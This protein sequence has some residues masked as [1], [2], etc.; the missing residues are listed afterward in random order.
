MAKE[1]GKVVNM[2]NEMKEAN[3]NLEDEVIIK[4][5]EKEFKLE[6]EYID[7]D[8]IQ[9]INEEYQEKLP[10][11]PMALVETGDGRSKNIQIPT[12]EEKYKMFNTKPENKKKIKAWEKK[13]KPYEKER[14]YRIAWELLKDEYKPKDSEGNIIPVDKAIEMWIDDKMLKYSD[15]LKIMNKGMSL[16]NFGDQ[17][18]KQDED[19]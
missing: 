4:I 3:A 12:D 11:K 2:W 1:N 10:K 14:V 17:M 19:Y 7:I 16:L 5:G 15:A 13:C 6:V 18:G 9:D 8:V